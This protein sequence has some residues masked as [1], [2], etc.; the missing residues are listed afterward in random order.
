MLFD[1]CNI[2]WD[3][4][5]DWLGLASHWVKV[6]CMYVYG[7]TLTRICASRVRRICSPVTRL[8][9]SGGSFFWSATKNDINTSIPAVRDEHVVVTE[10]VDGANIGFSLSGDRSSGPPRVLLSPVHAVRARAPLAD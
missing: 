1:C 7:S 4:R 3:G 5:Q 6:V 8:F 10:K 9:C 2:S